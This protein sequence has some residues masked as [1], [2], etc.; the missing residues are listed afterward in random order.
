MSLEAL[1]TV[2]QKSHAEVSAE[3]LKLREKFEVM[4]L[5]LKEAEERASA[6]SQKV[7]MLTSSWDS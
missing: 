1:V 4:D 7:G 3:A 5:Q 6:V 2:T